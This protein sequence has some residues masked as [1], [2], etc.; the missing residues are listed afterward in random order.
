MNLDIKILAAIKE[1][2]LAKEFK[3]QE[4]NNLVII[5]NEIDR[6]LL[7]YE[8]AQKNEDKEDDQKEPN[9]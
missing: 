3:V 6:V 5:L 2:L 1:L 4:M 8:K 9:S 7:E